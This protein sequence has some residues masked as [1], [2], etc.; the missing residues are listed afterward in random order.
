MPNIVITGYGIVSAIGNDA[1]S[2]LD[3]LRSKRSG[4]GKMEYLASVHNEL[5]VGE[6]KLSNQEMKKMLGGPQDSVW[7]RTILLG[8]LAARQAIAHSGLR[9]DGEVRRIAF[10]SGTTVGGMDVTE[11]Y[12][13]QMKSDDRA[14]SLFAQHD[15]GASTVESARLAGVTDAQTTTVSTACSS[16]LNAI[17]LASE[18][19]KNDE[20]DIVVAGGAEALSLFH[21]NGFNTLM[22]LDRERCRPFDA[23]RA[24]LNLGEGAA[25][26]VLERE[27]DARERRAEIHAYISGYA[28]ACDAF[29]QTA[30]SD[31]GEGAYL[32]MSSALAM[33]GLQA[34]DI[35]YVNAH[36]TG[37]PN[38][39]ASESQALRRIFGECM[40]HVSS[41]KSYTGH[42]T[43]AS[44]SIE[45]VISL[46]A[47]KHGFVPASLGW[48]NP[49][50]GLI[51]PSQGAEG[52]E[53]THVLCNSFGFGGNDSSLI[54]SESVPEEGSSRSVASPRVV[55]AAEYVID[56]AEQ[57]KQSRKWISPMEGRRM[58]KLLKSAIV[59]SL[60]A[61]EQAGLQCPDAIVTATRYGMLDVSVRFLHDM[62]RGGEEQLS[63]TLFMQ[64][65]HNTI[66]STIAIRTHCHGYNITYS[67]GE[68][69]MDWAMRDARRLIQTGRA[70]TVLVGLH[71]EATPEVNDI[72]CRMGR[73]PLPELYSRV[74]VL[75]AGETS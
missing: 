43:S 64:S 51:I 34:S 23:S 72:L 1:E 74:L 53:L 9:L 45:V 61:L 63:P 35:R 20:A 73:E 10:I 66:S 75:K 29:H 68:E 65:T 18:M 41:T 49:A 60:E 25:Y 6:V 15:S 28:N 69:S 38:N 27:R 26:L 44:G 55:V 48:L 56:D 70:K 14:L 16:A 46:L 62:N 36:G 58:G 71:D 21:L 32:S 2:V 12:F 54:L 33:A 31:D 7:S 47:M 5:P 17:I 24:G 13:E 4:I 8:A 22:I 67:H 37:T 57:L 59:S 39:D 42:T 11:R 40:P 52:V 30:T 50:D 3:A 19:L